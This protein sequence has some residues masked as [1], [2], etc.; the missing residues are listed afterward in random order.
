V[1]GHKVQVEQDWRRRPRGPVDRNPGP[2]CR[3]S[4]EAWRIMA[5]LRAARIAAGLSQTD[6]AN[7]I[8]LTKN[9]VADYEAGRIEAAITK[10]VRYAK[11]VGITELSIGN[12]L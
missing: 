8:G 3:V 6:L 10:V 9:R 2:T 1:W 5:Q 4:P 12:E 11:A 7:R